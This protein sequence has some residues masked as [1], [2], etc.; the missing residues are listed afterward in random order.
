MEN[1]LVVLNG[2]LS[3]LEDGD[4]VQGYI[5]RELVLQAVDLDELLIQG[6]LVEWSWKNSSVQCW[7]YC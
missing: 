2:D 4:L 1:E 6:F 5:G 7:T 3:L